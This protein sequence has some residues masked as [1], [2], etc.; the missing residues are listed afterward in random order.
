[1]NK[2]F[3]YWL[4]IFSA[5]ILVFAVLASIVEVRQVFSGEPPCLQVHV[6]GQ[7]EISP[8]LPVVYRIL[9]RHG[10]S[11]KAI[12]GVNADFRLQSSTGN[13]ID[14]AANTSGADG[15]CSVTL[16]V[17]EEA[18]AGLY[19]LNVQ[20]NFRGR[21]IYLSKQVKVE[22]KTRILVTTDKP[23]Y[24]P[25]QT[26]HMRLLGLSSANQR[27]LSEKKASLEVEDPKGNIVF[28]KRS[29]TS[30]FGIFSADFQLAHQVNLG[31]YTIRAVIDGIDS[32]REV[33]VKHYR[34]PPFALKLSTS[35]GYYGPGDTIE[36]KLSAQYIFGKPVANGQVN[37]VAKTMVEKMRT[38]AT[39]S[40][41]TD[42]SGLWQF[43][44]PLGRYFIGHG[45]T[46]GDA[47]VVLEASVTDATGHAEK[48]SLQCRVTKSP[49]RV[50][51]IC[52]G[53]LVP[54]KENRCF[55][56]ATYADGTPA[57]VNLNLREN[58][59]VKV[60]QKS[61]QTSALGLAIATFEPKEWIVSL[62][63]KAKDQLGNEFAKT[64]A[65]GSKRVQKSL[66]VRTDRAIYLGGQ[67]VALSVLSSISQGRVFVDVIKDGQIVWS[68]ASDLKKGE[69]NLSLD[70]PPDV[71]GTLEIRAYHINDKAETFSARRV[72]QVLEAQ[73]LKIAAKLDKNSYRP[74]EEAKL[75]LR[76]TDN[77]GKG[78]ASAIGCAAV[79][80]AVFALSEARPGL[81]RVF[82]EL[83]KELLQ[84][85]FQLASAVPFGT[86]QIFDGSIVRQEAAMAARVFYGVARGSDYQLGVVQSEPY[87]VLLKQFYETRYSSSSYVM[88]QL[89]VLALIIALVLMFIVFI[90]AC[91]AAKEPP[92]K[93]VSDEVASEFKSIVTEG[94]FIC[95]GCLVLVIFLGVPDY[96]REIGSFHVLVTLLA[97]A[98]GVFLLVRAIKRL[99]KNEVSATRSCLRKVFSLM[100]FVHVSLCVGFAA[101]AYRTVFHQF[102][103]GRSIRWFSKPL[104]D[105]LG[106]L[107]LLLVIAIVVNFIFI[108]RARHYALVLKDMLHFPVGCALV[109]GFI[110]VLP[111]MSLIFGGGSVQ[112]V[113][114]SVD[115]ALNR[116]IVEKP[117]S[118]A[119]RNGG[120]KAPTRVRR[121]FPET[122]YWRPQIITDD[123]GK[124]EL[125][126]P[127]A[128]S[129]TQWRFSASAVSREG[130]LGSLTKH[131]PVFQPFFVDIDA[132]LA[133]TQNDEIEIP[134]TVY[135]YLEKEQ[136][137]KLEI[138]EDSWFTLIGQAERELVVGSKKVAAVNVRVKALKAG[139]HRLLVDANGS[140]MSDAIERQIKVEP[141]GKEFVQTFNGRLEKALS[142]DVIIPNDAIDGAMDLYVKMYPGPFSQVLEGL[143]GLL[144][145]P[146][147]CFEQTS[148]TTYPNVLVLQYLR[149]TGKTKPEIEAKALEYIK[150]GYQR[151]L[152]FE[153]SGGG[154]E[155]FGK[156]P[157]NNILTAY[158]VLE[159]ADMSKVT[160][161]DPAL[162]SRTREWL[163]ADRRPDGSFVATSEG[164]QDGAIDDKRDNKLRTTAYIT[165]A[166]AEAFPNDRR[167]EK[168]L[169][170]LFENLNKCEDPYTLAMM[171]NAFVMAKD[172]RADKLVDKLSGLAKEKDGLF[173]WEAKSTSGSFSSRGN[174]LTYETTAIAIHA[175]IKSGKRLTM[176]NKALAYLISQKDDQGTW[177]S[178]QAT[179]HCLRALLASAAGAPM[180]DGT[181]VKVLVDGKEQANL[182]F[183]KENSD[184]LRLVALKDKIK[185][186][187]TTVKLEIS[188]TAGAIAYQIVARYYVPWPKTRVTPVKKAL[189]IDVQYDVDTIA[190][191]DLLKARVEVSYNRPGASNMALVELGIPPG[192]SL[193]TNT[194]EKLVQRG[195]IARWSLAGNR[196]TLYFTTI[197][198][199]APITF[200]YA[201]R[202]RN[203][204][205]A[206]TPPSWIY[207]YYEPELRDLAE[208]VPIE[209]R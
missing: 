89:A 62:S 182:P 49:L 59:S 158:G 75:S 14:K 69:A 38:V 35:K 208:P 172:A 165:W 159:F 143:E 70:L 85:R 26:I 25:G 200:D 166:L 199:N 162:L 195:T 90:F 94:L 74:A 47:S 13:L 22:R 73:S 37:I 187:K 93:G 4:Q 133:L 7:W 167:L 10:K 154:F 97:S 206:L 107:L 131:I 24:Q 98:F 189:T 111:M 138:K 183:N 36:G 43:S 79:D 60:S 112:K 101:F 132:P 39:V 95:F 103:G 80:E 209:V 50:D 188:S 100:P 177:R 42:E 105:E 18:H 146:S 99:E 184:V 66:V 115:G 114:G 186:G 82:F 169:D 141:D 174:I 23:L 8:G 61:L 67:S 176:A 170:F 72:L 104:A 54:H 106:M 203:P 88:A 192:F 117:T 3:S 130:K 124:A 204:V 31:T 128:D 137:V 136:R 12:S 51:V 185:K 175:L 156:E 157:A 108:L 63:V 6:Y 142:Q 181:S 207:D 28:R 148:S 119:P 205:K 168:S 96:A 40:G 20:A 17:P 53:D 30:E 164:Y 190:I 140:T 48:K 44:L 196:I 139:L 113:L 144:R 102:Q 15:T 126:I 145:M 33:T 160:D 77:A 194:I 78:V 150:L 149:S 21:M 173:F 201:L 163:Y 84:P 178:T 11:G 91:Q 129:I 120:H 152:T 83:E 116:A 118:M 65:L 46:G 45:L 121:H 202:A 171:T 2:G 197:R 198:S 34:L 122:L 32:H 125:T 52:E 127:L 16:A 1:M 55:I 64:F 161:I 123:E 41:R 9:A 147:G 179:I 68:T 191:N 135:N 110:I 57:E 58:D 81:E 153:V 134:I 109:V 86:D 71:T 27:P 151:L 76:V 87:D 19:T 155:W 180:E 29:K 92:V 5:I 56:I 193:E